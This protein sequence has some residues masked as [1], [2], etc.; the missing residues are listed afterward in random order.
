VQLNEIEHQL[1]HVPC[2]GVF[3]DHHDDDLPLFALTRYRPNGT[4]DTAFGDGGTATL[5]FPNQWQ[6]N[7]TGDY[8]RKNRWMRQKEIDFDVWENARAR[9]SWRSSASRRSFP[10]IATTRRSALEQ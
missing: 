2:C 4:V 8:R 10:R 7:K 6:A 3:V 9:S 5:T 1:E